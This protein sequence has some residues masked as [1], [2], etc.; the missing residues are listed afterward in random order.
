MNINRLRV[1]G[2]YNLDIVFKKINI[3]LGQNRTGK[4][5]LMKLIMYALGVNVDDFIVEISKNKKCEQVELDITT[6]SL[7]KFKIIRKLP[8][9]ESVLIIPIKEDDSLDDEHLEL[10]SLEEF[11]NFLLKE[12]G[13]SIK[14]IAY[15]NQHTSLRF[16]YLLRSVIVDQETSAYKIFSDIGGRKN[17]YINNRVEIKK[18]I[19]EEIL[20]K[21]NAELHLKKIE[22]KKLM[23]DKREIN[24]FLNYATEMINE[25]KEKLELKSLTKIKSKIE[26]IEKEKDELLEMKNNK[27]LSLN[28][29]VFNS[30]NDEFIKLGQEKIIIQRELRGAKLEEKDIEL[31]INNVRKEINDLKK[32]IVARQVIT[33]IPVTICPVCFKEIEL[34][35]TEKKECPNC[36]RDFEASDIENITNY[37][38]M[39]IESEKE[40]IY[41]KESFNRKTLSVSEKLKSI[42]K[43]LRTIKE[44]ELKRIKANEEPIEKM[45]KEILVYFEKLAKEQEMLKNLNDVLEKRVKQKSRKD[46]LDEKINALRDEIGTIEK[47][48][49]S[50]DND[51]RIEW[52]ENYFKLLKT[53]Y[54][55]VESSYLDDNYLPKLEGLDV[56]EV[57]SASLK[58]ATRLAY[59]LSLF[60]LKKKEINH[61][62][63]I[64]F[65]SPKDKDLDTDKYIKFL[66]EINKNNE[67]QIFI[68]SSIKEKD[69]FKNL[70]SKKDLFYLELDMF[71]KLL[72][73]SKE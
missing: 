13:Y 18:A 55:D 68:S 60:E 23:S 14:K 30:E 7:N 40:A 11:S 26:K 10:F 1:K 38:K 44:K 48:L 37:L 43:N 20:K 59:V 73:N 56:R 33:K 41:L 70:R 39:L 63:F 29:K 50:I 45:L 16:Y 35:V 27:I 53:I 51:I 9:S 66:E 62:G 54:T 17:D 15:G 64:Y 34:E 8:L 21:D 12:E 52:E 28:K 47:D 67:G 6:K 69:Y 22:L 57:S 2:E 58:V 31:T 72:I 46:G 24:S 71:N 5:T 65:D 42:E 3:I 19:I 61:L 49:L 4:T 32:M 36:H 25:Y